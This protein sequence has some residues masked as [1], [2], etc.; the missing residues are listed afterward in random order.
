MNAPL[1]FNDALLIADQAFLPFDCVAW[2]P[3]EGSSTVSISVVD[4]RNTRV[5]GR[6][7]L[8]SDIYRDPVQLAQALN[9]SREE[10]RSKGVA[11]APWSMPL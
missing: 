4:R 11:L 5:L 10:L 3:Q 2:T 7:L 8:S 6:T 9:Q 1:R